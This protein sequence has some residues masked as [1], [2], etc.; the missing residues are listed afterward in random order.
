VARKKDIVKR[1]N[2][3]T[4]MSWDG[5]EVTDPLCEEAANEIMRL[6]TMTHLLAGE[7]STYGP[8]AVYSPDQVWQQFYAEARRG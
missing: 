5:D 2:A 8:Y 4:E 3:V 7:L 6:R 1:L